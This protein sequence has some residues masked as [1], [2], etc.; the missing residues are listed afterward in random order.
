M[1]QIKTLLLQGPAGGYFVS[2]PALAYANVIT[3]KRNGSRNYQVEEAPTGESPNVYHDAGVGKL[4]F[5]PDLPFNFSNVDDTGARIIE[6]I[7]VLY[8]GGEGIVDTPPI[9]P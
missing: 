8:T 3:V 6:F 1:T 2:D 5:S 4:N 7:H 9:T